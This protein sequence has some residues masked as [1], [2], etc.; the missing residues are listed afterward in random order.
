MAHD[1]M[2]QHKP[3]LFCCDANMCLLDIHDTIEEI[4]RTSGKHTYMPKITTAAWLP[5]QI[6]N[7]ATRTS[8]LGLDTVA[9]FY[10]S[11]D[12]TSTEQARKASVS[13]LV[14][15]SKITTL[16]SAS[17]DLAWD[18][19]CRGRKLY[20]GFMQEDGAP[21]G[22]QSRLERMFSPPSKLTADEAQLKV[23][24]RRFLRPHTNEHDHAIL[25]SV[26]NQNT[27][28]YERVEQV[29]SLIHI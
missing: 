10:L 2:H 19:E 17:G 15:K 25:R 16:V 12:D 23:Q 28:Y 13:P 8:A 26:S 18:E 9:I 3:Q 11:Y 5:F 1:M 21:P 4:H 29:L 6:G 27:V 22:L 14:G 24:L 7:K 20:A